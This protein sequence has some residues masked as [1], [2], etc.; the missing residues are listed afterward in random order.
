[1]HQSGQ[2]VVQ[3]FEYSQV[4]ILLADWANLAYEKDPL[5]REGGGEAEGDKG[6]ASI[7]NAKQI[8]DYYDRNSRTNIKLFDKYL[9]VKACL[10]I[11]RIQFIKRV[12]GKE[13]F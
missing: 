13:A 3:P 11:T 5:W 2:L 12:D 8:C 7:W 10:A 4:N 6:R 1:M 9:I